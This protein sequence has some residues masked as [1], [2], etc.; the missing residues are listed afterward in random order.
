MIQILVLAKFSLNEFFNFVRQCYLYGTFLTYSLKAQ[1][2]EIYLAEIRF[3]RK[4]FIKER[5]AEV[6][7]KICPSPILRAAFQ[8]ST[9]LRT[10]FGN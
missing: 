5:G 8:D 9:P 6:F 4:A 2:S 10:S 3:I 7:R 1:S